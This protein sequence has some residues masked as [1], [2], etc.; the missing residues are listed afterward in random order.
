MAT[1][2][3]LARDGGQT[4]A[5][6]DSAVRRLERLSGDDNAPR[7]RGWPMLAGS[8][9]SVPAAVALMVRASDHGH[10]LLTAVYVAGLVA[11][12]GVGWVYHLGRWSPP[13]RGRLRRLDHVVIYFFIAASYTPICA[14]G[15]HDGLAWVLL[16]VTWL[17]AVLGITAKL[18]SFEGSRVI[19]GTMYIVV[20]WVAVFGMVD[21]VNRLG[22]TDTLLMFGGGALYTGGAIVLA[23]RRPDPAPEVF[24][25]HEV[26]HSMVLAASA[27]HYLLIWRLIGR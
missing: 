3:G 15:L 16:T 17:G 6:V 24:G 25:Y 12:Y 18:V 21:F 19:G 26:W 13:A 4:E 9:V 23:A 11:L 1:S 8:V 5:M 14:V 20:G 2:P 10:A 7:L 22:W 27:L